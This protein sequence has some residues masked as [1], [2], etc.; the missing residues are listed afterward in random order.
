M[1]LRWQPF[2]GSD[3]SSGERKSFEVLV[4]SLTKHRWPVQNKLNCLFFL[5]VT[6]NKKQIY[7]PWGPWEIV[8]DMLRHREGG[9]EVINF[10]Q[11][12]ANCNWDT[13]H[14]TLYIRKGLCYISGAWFVRVQ[15]LG[16]TRTGFSCY[17]CLHGVSGQVCEPRVLHRDLAAR[18]RSSSWKR[19]Q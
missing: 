15:D 2:T 13:I 11:T 16:R 18:F 7:R 9:G 12:I 3:L 5:H 14:K 17:S 8:S 1:K 6:D 4:P 10:G 19:I